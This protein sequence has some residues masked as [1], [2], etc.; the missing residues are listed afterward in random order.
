MND[1]PQRGRYILFGPGAAAG[2][3][4]D[5]ANRLG[6]ACGRIEFRPFERGEH[7]SRA[8]D[9]VGGRHAGVLAALHGEPAGITANDRLLQL[10]LFLMSLRD[11]GAASVTVVAPYLPYMRKDR[12]TNP[13]DP[14]NAR[15]VAELFEA[16]GISRLLVVEPHNLSAFENAFRLPTTP[17]PLAP[18]LAD[19]LELQRPADPLVLVSPDVGG[20]KRVQELQALLAA[21]GRVDAGLAFVEKRRSADVV[22]G[23]AIV[24]DVGGRRCLIVDDLIASGGTIA[25]AAQAC[26]RQG[27]TAVHAA[28]AHAL[29]VSDTA[30]QLGDARLDRLVVTDSI[31]VD[32]GVAARL[33]LEVVSLAPYLAEA[34]RRTWSG[35]PLEAVTELGRQPGQDFS[36]PGLPPGWRVR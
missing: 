19:W 13:R 14:L 33:P 8:L 16:T 10:W 27:A 5:V 29:F 34:L 26:R 2:L 12:R 15:Y 28:A 30:A 9:D 11:A 35:E 7:K 32:P 31:P 17:L 20:V 24:G 23:G 22:T 1:L 6:V 3:A 36:G 4:R 25:R 21:R 18:L